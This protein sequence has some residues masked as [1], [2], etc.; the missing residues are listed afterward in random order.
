[1]DNKGFSFVLEAFAEL[2]FNSSRSLEQNSTGKHVTS[3]DSAHTSLWF[4]MTVDL[5][6]LQDANEYTV[7]VVCIRKQTLVILTQIRFIRA[8]YLDS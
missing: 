1:M 3:P 5:L 7:E 2:T 6:Y 4:D 8:V